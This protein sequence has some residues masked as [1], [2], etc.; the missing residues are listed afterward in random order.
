MIPKF[1]FQFKSLPWILD[2]NTQLYSP[3]FDLDTQKASQIWPVHDEILIFP[4]K[5]SSFY[6]LP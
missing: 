2:S 6:N 1:H 4:S 3:Q 5:T